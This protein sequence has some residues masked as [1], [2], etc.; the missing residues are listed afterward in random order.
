[1]P[2]FEYTA[3]NTTNGQIQKGQLEVASRD[4]VNSYLRKNRLILVSVREAPKKININI[5]GPQRIKTRDIVVFT[6]QFATMINAGLPLVQSLNI[7]AQQTENKSLA[8]VT[9][10]VVY[11]VESG[12]TLADA[13]AKHPRA[14]SDLYVNMVAAGEAGGI[15]DTILQRLATFLEKNDALVRKVK[16][17]MVYPA[18]ICTVAIIAI[19]V[20]LVFVIP[21]FQEMFASVNLELPLP[22]RVVI[23][24]SAFLVGYW[25][26]ILAGIAAAIFGVRRYY[27]TVNGRKQIDAM[28]LNSPVLGDLL[29]KSAV[30]RFTRTL[31]TLIS[32]GVSILEGLEITA[33]TAGNM[34]IHDAVMASRQSIAGGETIAAPLEKSKVFPPMVISM[35][36]VGEQTGGL[37]EMLSKIADF[38]D[39]EVDVAVSALLSLM[40]PVMIVILGVVVGGMVV[41]MYLPIFDMMNAVQ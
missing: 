30:S 18:V 16:G 37:D 31:G 17:A 32:S 6:R 26:L 28:L 3:R 33:K 19:A 36:A 27:A 24:M 22:T 1:M 23:G 7:L 21:V 40:E 8:E 39:E 38:Y 15:L 34:V 13:F 29:R 41:A 20:L 2:L 9:K 10:A 11:D 12:N 35:I 5:G 25:Y 14:F 4:D